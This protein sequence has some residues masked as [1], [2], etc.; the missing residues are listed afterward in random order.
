M[1]HRTIHGISHSALTI[2]IAWVRTVNVGQGLLHS[3]I[4]AKSVMAVLEIDHRAM[5][6]K[7]SPR[8]DDADR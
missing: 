1:P 5:P 4:L 2:L 6:R 8:I 3:I 7:S